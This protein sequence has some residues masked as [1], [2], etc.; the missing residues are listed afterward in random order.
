MQ[1][2]LFSIFNVLFAFYILTYN[3]NREYLFVSKL[4]KNIEKNVNQEEPQSQETENDLDNSLDYM[5]K[6]FF[7]PFLYK[8]LELKVLLNNAPNRNL[9][10]YLPQEY[11][12]IHIPPPQYN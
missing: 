11:F 5:C 2:C 10:N 12:E 3:L 4:C 7:H 8:P 9:I 6:T 1:N